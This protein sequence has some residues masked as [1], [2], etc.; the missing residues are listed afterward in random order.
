MIVAASQ[1]CEFPNECRIIRNAVA[2]RYAERLNM[3]LLH[4]AMME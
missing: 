2:E 1:W 3:Q 4:A